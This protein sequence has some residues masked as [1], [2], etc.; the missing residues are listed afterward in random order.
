MGSSLKDVAEPSA[1]HG[2][3]TTDDGQGVTMDERIK[4][5]KRQKHNHESTK[6]RKHE[7]ER[8]VGQPTA[9]ASTSAQ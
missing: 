7:K 6:G 4:L 5:A 3:P 9:A 2:Q 8:R 1:D